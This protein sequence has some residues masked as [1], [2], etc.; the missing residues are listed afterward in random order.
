[1]IGNKGKIYV[2]GGYG[3][4]KCEV[5]DINSK[6]WK[7]MPDLIEKERQRSM[8]FVEKNFLYCFMGINQ[9]G[10]LTTVEKLNLDNMSAGWESV[11][12]DTCNEKINLKFYGAGI[13]RMNNCNKIYFIGGKKEKRKEEAYKRTIYEFSFDDYKMTKSDFKIEND[14]VF[15]ENKL[16]AM[17]ENDC[18][19]FINVG[20]GFLISMPNLVK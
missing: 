7:E 4:N 2:I 6:T 15:V 9:N 13:I 10:F 8:L 1:M 11:I 12:V 16:F 20:N 17:D 14:L 18:G 19:N 5:Y 3:S